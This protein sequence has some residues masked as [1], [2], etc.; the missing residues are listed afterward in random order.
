[1]LF[2][3]AFILALAITM[4][5]LPPLMTAARRLSLVDIPDQRKVHTKAIPRVGGIA[6][7]IGASV[8]LL[9]WLP[10]NVQWGS[11]LIALA[12]LLVFTVWDDSQDIDYRFKFIGQI[13]AA[14]IVVFWGGVK[15][16]I[17][18]FMGIDPVSDFIS[19]PITLFFIVGITNA[20]NL[21]DGLDGLAAGVMFI[22]LSVMALLAYF[23]NADEIILIALV[24]IGAIFGFLR[25]NTFPAQVFM[26]DAGSQFLGFTAGVLAIV[27]TQSAS[28]PLNPVLPLLLLGVPIIDTAFVMIKRLSKGRSLFS[29]DKNHIHHQLLDLGFAHYEAVSII[30][31]VQIMFVASAIGLRY[32]SDSAAFGVYGLI[33]GVSL[34]GLLFAKN[35]NIHFKQSGLTR[36]IE[37]IDHSSRYKY[38]SIL[39]MQSWMAIYLVCGGILVRSVPFD[40]GLISL[41]L[42]ILLFLRLVWSE[43][44][45]FFPLRLL[46]FPAIAF[47]LYLIHTD[48]N[49]AEV[50]SSDLRIVV[51]VVLIILMLFSLR[52]IKRETFSATPT[53][54]LVV[55]LAAGLGLLYQQGL[56]V[57]E[58]VPVLTEIIIFF[59]AAEIIMKQMKTVWNPFMIGMLVLLATMTVRLI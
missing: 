16:S 12:I 20:V 33:S 19:I 17:L 41:I 51:L 34:A 13:I 55:F 43:K 31:L 2:F 9:V 24:V 52:Y 22:S 28:P 6:M 49:T 3:I 56:I 26:G 1:M 27:L 25:Y 10:F 39:I 15:L 38:L 40:M 46:V 5:I 47:G 37:K 36:I 42:L 29:P 44:L 8:P 18:P 7:V 30:Y 14:C 4:V 59:Y 58:F 21:S 57:S 50:I 35:K 53:D 54:I 23:Q 48:E 45:R 32:Y 11:F